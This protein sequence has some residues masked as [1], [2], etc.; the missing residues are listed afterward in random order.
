VL[1]QIATATPQAGFGST[2]SAWIQVSRDK[3]PSLLKNGSFEAA[4][5]NQQQA[6]KDWETKGAP[7]GWSTWSSGGLGALKLLPGK[8]RNGSLAAALIGVTSGTYLQTLPVQPGERYL[9]MSWAKS[10]PEGSDGGA[11]LTVRFRQPDGKWHERQDLEP[12]T[13]IVTG[14]ND[15]QPLLLLAT[16][17]E[18]AG[19]MVIMPGASR[20]AEGATALHDDVAVYKLQ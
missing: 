5:T 19:G 7:E 8:G 6:E 9:V 18:G 15:W 16:I 17:P 20:Q 10:D 4:A 14:L 12:S 1:K 3:P 11:T 13:R 2:I